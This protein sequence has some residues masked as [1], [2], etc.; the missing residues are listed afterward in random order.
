MILDNEITPLKL[1]VQVNTLT[2][3]TNVKYIFVCCIWLWYVTEIYILFNV[4][5]N[6]IVSVRKLYW[7]DVKAKS[8]LKLCYEHLLLL[9]NEF[10]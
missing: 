1:G 2:T 7:C 8:I 5:V 10:L 9:L 3:S 4:V 6:Y